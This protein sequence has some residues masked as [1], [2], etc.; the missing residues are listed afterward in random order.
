MPAAVPP[1]QQPATVA[2]RFLLAAVAVHT[3]RATDLSV[4]V[5]AAGAR[6][7]LPHVWEATGWCPPDAEASSNGMAAYAMQVREVHC[8]RLASRRGSR[9]G[10]S[11]SCAAHTCGRRRQTSHGR[12]I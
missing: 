6:T 1:R 4:T 8:A 5:D 3:A 10:G 12:F 2:A 9:G 7:P 11:C